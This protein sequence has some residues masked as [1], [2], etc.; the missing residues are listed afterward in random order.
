MGV[1][2][3][4]RHGC[5][6]D[7]DPEAKMRAALARVLGADWPAATIGLERVTEQ[8]HS[9]ASVF[10]KHHA[11]LTERLRSITSGWAKWHADM[12]KGGDRSPLAVLARGLERYK[13]AK[14]NPSDKRAAPWLVVGDLTPRQVAALMPYLPN[15]LARRGRR[16][17][18]SKYDKLVDQLAARLAANPNE[19]PTTAARQI[20]ETNGRRTGVKR[21]A[22]HLVRLLNERGR[23]LLPINTSH[24]NR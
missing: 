17:G 22:D 11:E 23:E 20:L 1:P 13:A 3:S 18:V 9:A 8:V 14:A 21:A 15:P 7:G 2:G 4:V 10:A 24:P 16:K 12:T 5:D 6:M 19:L